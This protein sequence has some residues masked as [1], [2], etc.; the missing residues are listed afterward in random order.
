MTTSRFF[1]RLLPDAGAEL[2]LVG[3]ATLEG[4]HLADI[5]VFT[6]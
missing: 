4:D 6:P 2:L 1:H 5:E 3:G